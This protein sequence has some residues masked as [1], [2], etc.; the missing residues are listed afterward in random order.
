M[1]KTSYFY[2]NGRRKN[3]VATVRLYPE[4]SGDFSVNEKKVRQWSDT[5]EMFLIMD[6][7]LNILGIKKD[8]NVIARVSGGGKKAQAEAVRLGVARAVVLQNGDYREQLKKESLLTRD[9]RVKERKKPGLRK[10]RRSPQ[11]SKR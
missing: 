6:R 3:A 1:T 9:S 2:A 4:G 7:P 11:W 5:E 10:A 8:F